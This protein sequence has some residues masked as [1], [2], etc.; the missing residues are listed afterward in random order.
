M[1]ER[2]FN[3]SA[4]PSQM[5]LEVLEQAQRELVCYPGAGCSVLEMS[6]RTPVYQAIIDHAR[7]TLRELMNIPEDYAILFLQGGAS[8]QFSMVAMNLARQGE[9]MAYAVTGNFASKAYE[10]G[11]RWGNAV[12]VSDAEADHF[13]HIPTVTEVPADVAF[14]H[15]TGNNTIFGSAYHDPEKKLP[16]GVLSSKGAPAPVP[17]AAD[18]SSAILGQ[19]IDVTRY[20]VIYAGAQKN[21]GPA[22]LTVVIIRKDLLAR[23]KDPSVPS[24]L[25]YDIA[26]KNGS[27]YNTPPTFAIYLAGLMFDWVKKEG[28]V[29]AME[30]RNRVKA[31]MLYETI[32][33][34]RLF[35]NPVAPE[36]RSLMNVVFTLPNDR[37]SADF[38][39]LVKSR[40]L[41]NLK[42]HRLVGGFR[43]SIY[44]G[45][46]EEG[47]LKL[48]DAMKEFEIRNK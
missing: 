8:L 43:A 18:W 42:G 45:M 40:G 3:F 48:I 10:E 15:I 30:A 9:T 27:M 21:L 29:A 39:A 1:E 19:Q 28:G 16:A 23:E 38:L 36:D 14:V 33:N 24:M 12:K 13:T 46:P 20:G 47:V 34:S 26:E 6:H 41:I 37:L 5:P 22:G 31:A 17:L 32:D 7:D 44:N 25:R 2:V 4:G 11:C 35:R